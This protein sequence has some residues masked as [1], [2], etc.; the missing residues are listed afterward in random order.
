MPLSRPVASCL[1]GR[2]GMFAKG[3]KSQVG[4]EPRRSTGS[5]ATWGH[6]REPGGNDTDLDALDPLLPDT[7]AE[8]HDRTHLMPPL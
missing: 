3:A 2:Q 6:T 1:S 5:S 4:C 7:D 8:R